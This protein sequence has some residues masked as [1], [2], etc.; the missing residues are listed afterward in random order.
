MVAA[1][2]SLCLTAGVSASAGERVH[3]RVHAEPWYVST[4]TVV[5]LLAIVMDMAFDAPW[6]WGAAAFPLCLAASCA[7]RAEKVVWRSVL[8]L[9]W[10]VFVV[11]HLWLRGEVLHGLALSAAGGVLLAAALLVHVPRPVRATHRPAAT[12][13]DRESLDFCREQL[14]GRRVRDIEP[15]TGTMLTF[16]F[17]GTPVRLWLYRCAWNLSSAERVL[18]ASEDDRDTFLLRLGPLVG[19]RVEELDADRCNN[20]TLRFGG[21]LVLRAVAVASEA[22]PWMLFEPERWYLTAAPDG[23]FVREQL[24]AE[25]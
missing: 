9:G 19:Q 25:S 12:T 10:A 21:D 22:D 8:L 11:A 23:R 17:E 5:T 6:Q 15:G 3:E 1:D 14:V 4:W 13:V 2:A 20:L 24:A 16:S 18:G 7:L